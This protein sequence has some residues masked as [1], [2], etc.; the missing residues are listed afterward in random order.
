MEMLQNRG[1]D[2]MYDGLLRPRN[3]LHVAV[4]NVEH[5]DDRWSR[6]LRD[7]QHTSTI[8]VFVLAE[9]CQHQ[10]IYASN[11][12]NRY[13]SVTGSYYYH[14][15]EGLSRKWAPLRWMNE[16]SALKLDL[17]LEG[18]RFGLSGCCS[19]SEWMVSWRASTGVDHGIWR[20][21]APKIRVREWVSE[22]GLT[23]PS[24]HYRSFRR[25]S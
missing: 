12:T 15:H 3:Q 13:R 9:L 20:G 7:L 25:R 6:R 19:G 14:H 2:K 10:V 22:Y 23:S 24:T 11:Q 16:C 18:C 21:H 17:G 1:K 8:P 5:F 4:V